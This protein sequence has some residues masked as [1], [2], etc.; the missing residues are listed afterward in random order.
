VLTGLDLD[1]RAGELVSLLGANGSGKSTA[2]RCLA[3]LRPAD[4]GTIVLEG[5]PLGARAPD[6]CR[7]AM[8][9]QAPQLVRRLSVIDNVC[10][11]ALGRLPL[12]Q[13][14]ARLLFP[15]ALREEAMRCL[16]RVGLA[17]RAADRA[18]RLSGGQQQRVA[19]A[20]ALCQGPALLLA[21][22]PVS[23]LDPASSEQVMELLVSLAHDGLA[24]LAVLHQTELAKRYSDRVVGLLGGT[25]VFDLPAGRLTP[26]AISSLYAS[27]T[28]KQ[29]VP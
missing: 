1:V 6:R 16:D 26:G 7:V 10:T 3:G 29:E 19:V 20:R 25:A 11:G 8:I 12:R 18:G 17:D 28:G 23:A 21:D 14:A 15:S 22:E 4:G 2:L 9:F 24:V 13:S 27:A 5:Q